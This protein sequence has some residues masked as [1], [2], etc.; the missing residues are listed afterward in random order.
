MRPK[1]T[2][3]IRKTGIISTITTGS[4]EMIVQV[5]LMALQH[6]VFKKSCILFRFHKSSI[7]HNNKL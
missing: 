5:F 7:F 3:T 4:F 2:G 6:N 1:D